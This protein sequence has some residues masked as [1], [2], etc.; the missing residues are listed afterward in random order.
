MVEVI[1]VTLKY[2][3]EKLL[4]E[5]NH[6]GHTGIKSSI[7]LWVITVPAILGVR[8]KQVMREAAYLVSKYNQESLYKKT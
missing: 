6:R 1:A 7:F 5:L 8:G 4:E 3:K 2:L